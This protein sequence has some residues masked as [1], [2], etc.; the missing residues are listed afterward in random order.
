[1]RKNWLQETYFFGTFSTR[2]SRCLFVLLIGNHTVF[3]VQFE[4]NLHLWVFQKAEIAR[5]KA[6]RAISAFE[7]LTSANKF[8]IEQEKP[9]DYLH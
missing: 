4:I 9:Y 6:A 1:M 7:K 3:F 5:A 8:Q 2:F